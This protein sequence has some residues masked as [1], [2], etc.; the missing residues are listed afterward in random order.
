MEPNLILIIS[1]MIYIYIYCVIFIIH[2]C[3]LQLFMYQSQLFYYPIF[4][5]VLFVV[6][7]ILWYVTIFCM[8][9]LFTLSTYLL[10]FSYIQLDR[11]IGF[12]F[13]IS[14]LCYFVYLVR[15]LFIV[16]IYVLIQA[17]VIVLR[18]Y[19]FC[20]EFCKFYISHLL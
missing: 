15:R 2:L 9:C 3:P 18:M 16:L 14:F 6:R 5:S 17:L 10:Q 11:L 20:F 19:A 1:L 13:I 4:M 8:L 7:Y 12:M